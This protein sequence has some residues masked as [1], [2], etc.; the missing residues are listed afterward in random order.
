[1][2]DDPDARSPEPLPEPL[3]AR[4]RQMTDVF[5]AIFAAIAAVDY[6]D[7]DQKKR[8]IDDVADSV[9]YWAEVESL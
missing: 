7:A 1:M 5:E 3:P 8:L 9:R 4:V 6:L 2:P